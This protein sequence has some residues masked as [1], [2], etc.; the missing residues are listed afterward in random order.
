V[1][2]KNS[3]NTKKNCILNNAGLL[4]KSPLYHAQR[5]SFGGR[6]R[7]EIG[8]VFDESAFERPFCFL[9]LCEFFFFFFFFFLN[10]QQH[11]VEDDV[12]HYCRII[13]II[14]IQQQEQEQQQQNE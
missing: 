8:I 6:F 3:K 7:R 11:D 4:V 5:R 13:I 12:F 14:I 1:H 9:S 10:K 2:E